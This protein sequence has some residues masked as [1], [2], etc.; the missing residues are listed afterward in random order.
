MKINKHNFGYE[1]SDLIRREK[2][3]YYYNMYIHRNKIKS[4]SNFKY[5]IIKRFEKLEDMIK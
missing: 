4:F 2:R 5:V 1:P 3:N